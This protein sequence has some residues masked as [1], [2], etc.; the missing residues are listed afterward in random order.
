ME[1]NPLVSVVIPAKNSGTVLETCFKYIKNQTY[2]NI[3]I[4]VVDSYS[5][6]KTQKICEQYKVRLIQFDDSKIRGHF[7]ATYKRNLGAKE[8]KG[9]FVYY[10]DADFELTPNV[11]AEAVAV[12]RKRND[13]VIVKEIVKGQGFWTRCKWLEQETYWGDDNVEAPRFFKKEVWNKLGG[14]DENLGAGCD[15]WDLYQRF[16]QKGYKVFR[17]KAPLYHNEGK[18]T[19]SHLWKKA[20][21]YGKDASKF[22]KKNPRGGLIYFFPIRPAYLKHWKMFV[23]YPLEGIGLIFMRI[24][25][26]LGGFAGIV[27]SK[28]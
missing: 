13:A 11:T 7:D 10:L 4:I 6:D 9:D 8:A 24:F 20:F 27:A 19:L 26:Y 1:N 3:E 5:K 25:E 28:I 17:I 21:L 2:L 23:K 14:L 15:D 18:I 22:V 16:R 12:C